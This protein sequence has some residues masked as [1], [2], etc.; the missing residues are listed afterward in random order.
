LASLI[1]AADAFNG[2]MESQTLAFPIRTRVFLATSSIS[3]NT[4]SS[5]FC[6]S[7]DATT[8]STPPGFAQITLHCLSPALQSSPPY[9]SPSS[10]VQQF[11][12][13]AASSSFSPSPIHLS[14]PAPLPVA[15]SPSLSPSVL[16]LK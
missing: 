11:D 3:S 12:L 5:R 13:P 16:P 1:F 7:L 15:V 14:T 6:T 10:P 4:V 8:Q 9:I 2:E